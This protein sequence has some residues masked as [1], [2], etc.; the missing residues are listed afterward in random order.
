M[1]ISQPLL[2]QRERAR[3]LELQEVQLAALSGLAA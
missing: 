1:F 2:S 3:R